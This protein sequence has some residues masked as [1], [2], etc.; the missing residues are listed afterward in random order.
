MVHQGQQDAEWDQQKKDKKELASCVVLAV[1]PTFWRPSKYECSSMPYEES[2]NLSYSI[3][4]I[5]QELW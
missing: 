2:K 4:H 5:K 3:K 1:K